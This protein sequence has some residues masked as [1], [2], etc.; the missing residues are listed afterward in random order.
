[1]R[2]KT[3]LYALMVAALLACN[4]FVANATRLYLLGPAATGAGDWSLNK[5]PM[6]V[7][8]GDTYTW[9]GELGDGELKF[10]FTN[11]WF[12]DSYGPVANGDSLKAGSIQLGLNS[13]GTDN[14]FA[15]KAGRYSLTVTL[16]ETPTLVVADG[17]DIADKG[18]AAADICP[19]VLYAIGNATEAGWTPANAIEMVETEYGKYEGGFYIKAG[20]NL[21]LKF[22]AQKEWGTQYGPQNDGEEVKAAGEYSLVKPASGDPKYHTTFTEDTYFKAQLDIPAGKMTLT[23]ATAPVKV[24]TTMWMI[25][26]ATGGY[27]FDDNA[28]EMAL[29]ATQDSVWTWSGDLAAGNLKFCGVWWQ[30]NYDTFGATEDD[31][32]LT[33]GNLPVQAINGYTIDHQFLVTAAGKY[34]LT[35]NLK[36][37]TLTV[38]GTTP[39]D[40][41][42]VGQYP[43]PAKVFRNGQ[44]YIL[45][46][47][48]LY[49]LTGRRQ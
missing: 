20:E 32:N 17:T 11:R 40:V 1:M 39:T 2:M 19:E 33:A 26:S 12:G 5:M 44:V 28:I 41:I 27:S 21:E 35:L 6:M 46:G 10:A 29:D 38:T 15:V 24:L 14:K 37:M 8:E 36:T 49:D 18:I 43:Q 30:W 16:G 34:S 23:P 4:V 48:A 31:V 13:N 9:V 22:L 25:G 3:K 47:D 7:Q 42:S 45:R